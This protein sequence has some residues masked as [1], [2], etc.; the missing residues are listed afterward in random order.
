MSA[1][2]SVEELILGNDST[3]FI[4]MHQ[5]QRKDGAAIQD[6]VNEVDPLDWPSTESNVV[7]EFKTDG[8]ATMAFPILFLYGK[9][10]PTNRARQH[11]ITLTEAFKHLIKFAEKLEN[12]KFEWRFAS[13]PR[14]LYWAL[15]MKQRHQLLSQANIYLCQHPADA[16]MTMEELKE[17]VNSMSANQMVNRLQRYVSKVQGTNQYWFFMQ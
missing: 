8:L 3:S 6:A 17:M 10:D 5:R 16:N 2:A 4:P 7:N 12:G 14:F 13:H 1:N 15:N 9:G 11:G